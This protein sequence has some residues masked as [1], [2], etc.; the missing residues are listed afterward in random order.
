MRTA[1]LPPPLRRR[2]HPPR[3]PCPLLW[4][5][6]P[7]RAPVRVLLERGRRWV[8]TSNKAAGATPCALRRKARASMANGTFPGRGQQEK[9]ADQRTLPWRFLPCASPLYFSEPLNPSVFP[10]VTRRLLMVNAPLALHSLR[11][12]ASAPLGARAG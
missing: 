3:V 5:S 12:K 11:R 10:A 7:C 2:R 1:G 4:P 6:L 9:F 8:G